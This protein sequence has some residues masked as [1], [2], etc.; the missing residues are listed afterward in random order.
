MDWYL[1]AIKFHEKKNQVAEDDKLPE[2]DKVMLHDIY[3][4]D[5][6]ES[7]CL[8]LPEFAY[9]KSQ[10][11]KLEGMQKFIDNDRD[12]V[13]I[14]LDVVDT[15]KHVFHDSYLDM[16]SSHSDLQISIDNKKFE[17][18]FDSAF[19]NKVWKD[20]EPYI[21]LTFK[22]FSVRFE[23]EK[24]F[25]MNEVKNY[26]AFKDFLKEVCEK[27]KNKQNMVENGLQGNDRIETREE[28]L[29][30]FK[31]QREKVSL[32]NNKKDNVK[33]NVKNVDLQHE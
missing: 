6:K 20:N 30:R 28:K 31:F 32:K 16:P 11:E 14:P 7:S 27:E 1:D 8:F 24:P 25:S 21:E 23:D 3:F 12:T 22:P 9:S 29:K 10:V 5:A 33:S 17:F 4:A 19:V 13:L 2:E 15:Y 26:I 18:L